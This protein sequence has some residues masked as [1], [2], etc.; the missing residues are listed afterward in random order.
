VKDFGVKELIAIILVV[1]TL[2]I[3][4]MLAFC[5]IKPA[6]RD[7]LNFLLGTWATGGFA[8][9][10]KRMFDG[11]DSSDTKNNTIASMAAALPQPKA[12]E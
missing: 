3:F 10:M 8:V 2:A 5:E 12:P 6:N 1:G 4:P 9:I 11:T 7:L